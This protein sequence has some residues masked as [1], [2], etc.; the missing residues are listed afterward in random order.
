MQRAITLKHQKSDRI[1]GSNLEKTRMKTGFGFVMMAYEY[2]S[3]CQIE[4][5]SLASALFCLLL[6]VRLNALSFSRRAQ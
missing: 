6:W 3:D 4:W 2:R 1:G 5:I